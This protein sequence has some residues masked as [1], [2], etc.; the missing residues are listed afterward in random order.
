VGKISS[1][2]VEDLATRSSRDFKD[3]SRLLGPNLE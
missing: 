2:Q 1:E 3:L